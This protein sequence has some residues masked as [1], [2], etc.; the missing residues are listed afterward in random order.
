[1]EKLLIGE[2]VNTHGIKGELKVRSFSDF[3]KQRLAKGQQIIAGIECF[4][5]E[6]A[7]EHQNVWLLKLVGFDDINQVERLRNV[8]LYVDR[9]SIS[10]LPNGQYYFFELVGCQVIDQF[11]QL[12]G[13]V[14]KVESTGFQE[15]LRVDTGS[16]MVLIPFI[17]VFIKHVNLGKQ[18]IEIHTIEG[19]I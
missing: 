7:R 8:K 5:V 2:I 14:S 19:L 17:P 9:A 4:T 13:V 6:Y 16:R 12:V 18:V 15:L 11:Q 3:M 1:M 10:K